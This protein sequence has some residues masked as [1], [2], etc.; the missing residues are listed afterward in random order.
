MKHVYAWLAFAAA[1]SLMGCNAAPM[2][3]VDFPLD[4]LRA[5][6]VAHWALDDGAGAVAMDRSGN[7]HDGQVTGGDWIA[8]GRFAGGLRLAAGDAITVPSFPTPTPNWTVS[9]WIRLSAE[10]LARDSETWVSILSVENYFAGGWQLNIDNRLPQPRFDLAY[11]APPLSAYVFAECECVAAG[12]WIHLAAVVDVEANRVTLY[13]DGAVG[14][15]ET[16]PSDIPPGDSTLYMGRWNMNGRL[17]SGDLDDI[18]IWSRA[19]T[20]A[21][22]AVVFAQSPP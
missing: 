21:E 7:G 8:D 4:G 9:T 17:L 11:W 12:R 19:L 16:R 5:G 15:Q 1:S 10:Q 6:L 13:V 2:E 3:A 20:S 18:T 22:I 14:D